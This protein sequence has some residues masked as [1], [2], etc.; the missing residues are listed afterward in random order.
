MDIETLWHAVII[1]NRL[2]LPSFELQSGSLSLTW[3]FCDLDYI[4]H[5]YVI[6][7]AKRAILSYGNIILFISYQLNNQVNLTSYLRYLLEVVLSSPFLFVYYSFI[8]KICYSSLV[9]LLIMLKDARPDPFLTSSYAL[10]VWVKKSCRM[11]SLFTG[12]A[13]SCIMFG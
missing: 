1:V 10:V 3:Y 8:Y 11:C 2:S 13:V 9:T 7:I 6:M 5:L 12:W 4:K